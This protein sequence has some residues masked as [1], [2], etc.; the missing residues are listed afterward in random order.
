MF[1]LKFPLA[2]LFSVLLAA[3][4]GSSDSV[5]PETG[6]ND[7]GTGGGGGDTPVNLSSVTY[8]PMNFFLQGEGYV[9]GEVFAGLMFDPLVKAYVIA[10]V[11]A[12]TLEPVTAS[13]N[14]FNI[15]VNGQAINRFEQY[16]MLQKIVGLPVELNTAIIIDASGTARSQV[17]KASLISA[18]NAYFDAVINS[19]DSVIRNQQ[20]TV[21]IYGDEIETP[22]DTFSDAAAAKTAAAS[23]I[24]TRWDQ[25]GGGSA[26]YEAIVN[27][28]G[29]Y[30]GTSPTD[31]FEEYDMVN[32]GIGDLLDGYDFSRSNH[33]MSKLS[34]SNVVLIGAGGMPSNNVFNAE[35]VTAAL[36]WQSLIVYDTDADTE[37]DGGDDPAEEDAS[38]IADSPVTYL[39]KPLFFVHVGGNSAEKTVTDLASVTI[40][41]SGY[42]FAAA[43]IAAQ[44]N[45]ISVRSRNN[46][47]H[48]VRFAVR[49]RDGKHNLLFSSRAA[50]YNF[51]LTTELDVSAYVEANDTDPVLFPIPDQVPARVE[52]TTANNDF[53]AGGRVRIADAPRLYPATRYTVTSYGAADYSWTVGG[54]SRT[55]AA[56]GSITIS[57]A[58]L[59][60]KVKLT[61]NSLLPLV[62]AETELLI[63]N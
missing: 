23:A 58:D 30:F 13:I 48:L 51:G 24:N 37:S 12:R 25:L 35:S 50:G 20:F 54:S 28:V 27:A 19:T 21:W 63:T 3:C 62:T 33:A 44:Q 36:N 16:A 7:G 9:D 4:G 53:L 56:D 59:N 17:N 32:D 5:I 11:G 45:S 47:Q 1:R 46:N 14:D 41:G 55:A 60:Q 10:P 2:I 42:N 18:V 34:L 15:S 29:S 49:E 31:S 8:F 39:G 22:L 52:I 43:L 38:P 61:N 57:T 6:G 26:T 40:D